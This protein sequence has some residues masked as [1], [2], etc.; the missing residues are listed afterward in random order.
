MRRLVMVAEQL[1]EAGN[2]IRR[3]GEPHERM[4]L[5]LLDNA[6]EIMMRRTVE[7]ELSHDEMWRR[8]D[9]LWKELPPVD[10]PRFEGPEYHLLPTKLRKAAAFEFA[11]R[12]DLLVHVRRLDADMAAVIKAL[13]KYRND[14]YHRENNRPKTLRAATIL[15]FE[16][17]CEL[18]NSLGDGFRSWYSGDDW[19][20]FLIRFEATNKSLFNGDLREAVTGKLRQLVGIGREELAWLLGTHL[21]SRFE[22]F[23]DNIEF[24]RSNAPIA[25]D[26]SA[27][28][29]IKRVDFWKV[30]GDDLARERKDRGFWGPISTL[31]AGYNPRYTTTDL[32]T[33]RADV[34]TL[35]VSKAGKLEVLAA[36]RQIEER[37]EPLE[38][39]VT[40]AVLELDH[41]IQLQVDIA[42]GK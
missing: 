13:H 17:C 18:L 7:L 14:A 31:I 19:T 8:I 29:H 41:A 28:M 11:G 38:E 15:Y 3:G 2:F 39:M 6:T 32:E 25:S 10:D 37:F 24:L 42:R 21:E 35:K 12:V 34:A 27:D 4:A 16:I 1:N 5:L 33:W 36:F 23:G 9:E 26:N 30:R 20:D 40:E 22:D